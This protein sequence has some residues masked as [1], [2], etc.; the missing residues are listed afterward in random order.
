MPFSSKRKGRRRIDL[1]NLPVFKPTFFRQTPI[2]L[3]LVFLCV[4]VFVA[5]L[6]FGYVY[7]AT[8][9]ESRAYGDVSINARLKALSD[10][11]TAQGHAA[12]VGH[13]LSDDAVEWVFA[14]G[15]FDSSG[16]VMA[17][18]MRARMEGKGLPDA[19]MRRTLDKLSSGEKS[20][21][22]TFFAPSPSDPRNCCR[23]QGK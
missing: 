9:T 5:A 3:T 6:V 7:L 16:Q 11:D 22:F 13:I 23:F 12:V 19:V 18:N 2:R 20:V 21:S 1:L 15:V 4:Y 8:T 10:V 14:K 17:Q